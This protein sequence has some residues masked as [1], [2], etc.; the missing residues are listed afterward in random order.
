[1]P[2]PLHISDMIRCV[3]TGL[4]HRDKELPPQISLYFFYVDLLKQVIYFYLMCIGIC[5]QECKV[6]ESLERVLLT[7]VDATVCWES[8][9]SP[10]EVLNC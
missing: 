3:T 8:N 1:M 2:P 6:S 9:P 4:E 5:L 7:V 10:L